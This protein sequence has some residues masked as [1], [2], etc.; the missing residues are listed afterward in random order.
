LTMVSATSTL[1][2]ERPHGA[3]TETTRT[4]LPS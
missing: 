2:V 1:Q 4:L 3:C